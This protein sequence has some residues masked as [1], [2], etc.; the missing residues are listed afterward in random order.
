MLSANESSY[1]HTALVI[2]AAYH[3]AQMHGGMDGSFFGGPSIE[4][5]EG[6]RIISR[7]TS[8]LLLLVYV[9]YLFFQVRN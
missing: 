9:A 1:V 5:E 8:I 2:P 4:G 7:G 6:L 3:S